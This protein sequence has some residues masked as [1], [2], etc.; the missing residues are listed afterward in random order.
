MSSRLDLINELLKF[1]DIEGL[2][3]CGAPEDEYESEA[4]MIADQIGEAEQRASNGKIS[5]EEA[6]CIVGAVW[7][8][9]FGRSDHQ[10][11][12]RRQ[13]A[14]CGRHRR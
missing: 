4:E 9:M 7:K 6:A 11:T 1:E 12:L 8:K 13:T 10:L 5:R 3:S 2:L 14:D